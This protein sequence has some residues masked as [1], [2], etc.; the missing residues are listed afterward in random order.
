MSNLSW[1]K[2]IPY[3]VIAGLFWWAL[4]S[5]YTRGT[6]FEI[7]KCEGEKAKADIDAMKELGK[8]RKEL[9][10]A[11][12]K[13]DTRATQIIG[14]YANEIEKLHND[15]NS[16]ND[17]RLYISA[18]KPICEAD[19]NSMPSSD[20]NSGQPAAEIRFEIPAT[21]GRAIRGDY[22]TA[23]GLE[24]RY[25]MLVDLIESRPDCFEKVK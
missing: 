20:K 21:L 13:A 8:L 4:D 25:N 2:V 17:K 19:R 16:V 3:L 14:A 6:E 9:D 7:A 22:F 1:L 12:E 10:A 11:R 23:A 5:E 15:L 24:M 18:K